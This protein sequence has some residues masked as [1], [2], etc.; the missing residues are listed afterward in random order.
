MVGFESSPLAFLLVLADFEVGVPRVGPEAD[1]F[2]GLLLS[3]GSSLGASFGLG[4]NTG[5]ISSSV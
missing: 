2:E 4:A 1:G 5:E 3:I